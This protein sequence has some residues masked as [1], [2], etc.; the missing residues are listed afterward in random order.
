MMGGSGGGE[1]GKRSGGAGKAQTRMEWEA[2]VVLAGE[3]PALQGLSAKP[4]AE[5]R[6]GRKMGW[7][8]V[9]ANALRRAD[10]EAA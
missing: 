1:F 9:G 4:D 7:G 5:G 3:P 2:G 10:G 6:S 8:G